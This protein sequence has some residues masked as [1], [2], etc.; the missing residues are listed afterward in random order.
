MQQ[1]D[2]SS[3][4]L[5]GQLE[6]PSTSGFQ[7]GS[8]LVTS[9]PNSLSEE[10]PLS[11]ITPDVLGQV[12]LEP[13]QLT[14]AL[15]K[16]GPI[17]EHDSS[18]SSKH[19][20][21]PSS[22]PGLTSGSGLTSSDLKLKCSSSAM[23]ARTHLPLNPCGAFRSLFSYR[24]SLRL[25]AKNKGVQRHSLLKAQCRKLKL[26]RLA[27]KLGRPFSSISP[28]ASTSSI[29]LFSTSPTTTDQ[30]P[31]PTSTDQPHP[32]TS[33]DQPHPLTS[34]N[35][36]LPPTAT[37]QPHPPTPSDRHSHPLEN[38]NPAFPLSQKEIQHIKITCGIIDDG[39]GPTANYCTEHANE[40]ETKLSSTSL[41]KF[42]SF[43]GFHLRH[44]R[45]LDAVWTRGGGRKSFLDLQY[46]RPYWIHSQAD[47]FQE[48]KSIS[49]QSGEVW[50]AI[51]DF[52]VLLSA[53]DKNG[54]PTNVSDILGF[55]ETVNETGL[56]DLPILNRLS[57][58]RR[59]PTLERLD[60][61]F[62]SQG[63]L[64]SFP[65]STLRALPRPRSDHSP[66]L[67]TAFSFVQSS[68]LFRFE[69]FWLRYPSLYMV[70]SNSWNASVMDIEPS[71]RF[72]RKIKLVSEALKIWSAGISSSI[73]I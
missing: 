36:L 16:S 18:L 25:A 14:M 47:F 55:R 73:T 49:R 38:L 60:R 28:S 9:N 5:G 48:L 56:T 33:T 42:H 63:W 37:D 2:G 19:D 13:G 70:V 57:N 59:S 50:A 12:S 10:N 22:G 21:S 53:N 54:P 31:P 46:L 32:P 66:L 51:G 43:C 8:D 6:V 24:R 64:S 34:T 11:A 29:H 58:G 15:G 40:E 26:A 3:R 4:P 67:L 35:Q 20:S 68:H 1:G 23:E 27:T 62:I 30:L 44:F 41:A 45:T 65:R 71:T 7:M 72:Q 17:V 39:I 52:N 69:T 61:A